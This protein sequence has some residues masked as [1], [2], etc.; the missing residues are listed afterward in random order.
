MLANPWWLLGLFVVAAL[1]GLYV[2][3][4]RRRTSRAMKFAN[5]EILKSVTPK[6]DRSIP[7]RALRGARRRAGVADDR[8]AGPSPTAK[9]RATRHGH[10][11][12]G[13]LARLMNAT[14][15]A[16]SRI[17]TAQEAAKKFATELTKGINLGLVSFAGRRPR[18]SVRRPTTMRRKPPSTSCSSTIRRRPARASSPRWTDPDPQPHCLA[19]R[20]RRHRRTSSCSPTANRPCRRA[21]MRRGGRSRP[22]AKRGSAAFRSR[23]S[24]GTRSGVV[25]IE[26]ERIPV[27]VDDASLK[28]IRSSARQAA[29]LHRLEP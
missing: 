12:H 9:C 3:I 17:K 20:R 8:L 22:R 7:P 1:V 24:P 2:Y 6:A 18:W 5:L 13:R 21:K 15:V 16:P 19:V 23:P 25:E 14:D 10:A 26:G 29:V 4:Q 11:G 28:K 27:P